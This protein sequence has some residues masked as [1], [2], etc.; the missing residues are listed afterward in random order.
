MRKKRHK[1]ELFSRR[2]VYIDDR[3][4]H[5]ICPLKLKGI[6]ETILEKFR[7]DPNNLENTIKRTM[8]YLNS[9]ELNEIKFGSFLLRRFFSEL[10]RI[11]DELIT[12]GHRLDYKIDK[13]LENDLINSI[14]K[15]LTIESN[16]DII[17]ELTWALVNITYFDAENGGYSYIKQF[18]NQN[19][20]NIFYKLIKIGDNEIL[21]N[22]YQFLTNCNIESDEF[23]KFIFNDENFIKLCIMKYLEQNKPDP[24]EQ[25]AKKAAIYFFISL[26]RLSNSL[27]EKQKVTF[28]NIFV[29]FLGVKFDNDIL[30]H[31]IVGLRYLFDYD[32]SKEKIVYNIIKKNNYE[33]FDKLFSTINDIYQND[34]KFKGMDTILYNVIVIILDFVHL[35]EEKD[36]IFLIQNTQL[37]NFV[38]Y[39]YDKIYF[40]QYKNRILEIIVKLSHHTS[41]VVLNM[42]KN[43]DDFVNDIIKKSLNSPDFSIRIQ[44]IEIIYYMLSLRSLDINIILYNNGVINNIITICLLNEED[45][46][47]L[48]YILYSILYFINGINHLE[49]KFKKEIINDLIKIGISN[50][51][52]N[53]TTRFNEE[54][55]L[56]INQINTE[57]KNILNSEDNEESNKEIKINDSRNII[58]NNNQNVDLSSNN[59]FANIAKS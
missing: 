21:I 43:R 26:S 51:L 47:F 15:V 10:A 28:Y 34:P 9:K 19:Y 48:R 49:N 3:T 50:G 32:K 36:I 45:K 42:I 11:D 14:G 59:P 37:M 20:L 16:I 35:S 2:N 29:K 33:I 39:F 40:K 31:V 5:L 8:K 25:E 6:P 17:S 44:G 18:I 23:T 46:G 12:T 1:Q 55:L 54:H 13:F 52:E 22:T 30:M 38:I 56:I 57:M 7:I 41:V 53:N 58:S 4:R 27:K 24:F